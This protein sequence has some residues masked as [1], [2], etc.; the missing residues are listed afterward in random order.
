MKLSK[1]LP[2]ILTAF[3]FLAFFLLGRRFTREE[4][5]LYLENVGP[6]GPVVLFFLFILVNI[7]APLSNSPIVF[8]GYYAYGRWVIAIALFAGLVSSIVNFFV[9]RYFGRKIV[10]K[11]IGEENIKKADKF[12]QGNGLLMLFVLR[13]FQ[14]GYFDYL[15]YVIGLTNLNFKPY[16]IVTLLGFIP[17][18]LLWYLFSLLA[19]SAIEF[20]IYSATMGG[21][22][23]IIFFV[24]FF[25]VEYIK[26][27]TK[28][29]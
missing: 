16:I 7:V 14:S 11:L 5:N 10:I 19:D 28:T 23:S 13:V 25:L 17:A 18:G 21:T 22:L 8:A 12:I 9:A 2:Y 26:K 15:S 6:L 29:Q 27:K 3:I 1:Y 24:G 4:I 20:T